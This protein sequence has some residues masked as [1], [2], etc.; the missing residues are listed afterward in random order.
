VEKDPRAR[1]ITPDERHALG[2]A[3][4]SNGKKQIDAFC[5]Q[6]LGPSPS[7]AVAPSER[8]K[9]GNPSPGVKKPHK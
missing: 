5:G 6:L 1:P 7:A 2:D 4:G 8:V 9:P 3:A